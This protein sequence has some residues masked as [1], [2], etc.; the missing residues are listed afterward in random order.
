MNTTPRQASTEQI[1][2]PLFVKRINS[3]KRILLTSHIRPDGDC[4]GS[5]VAIC[6]AL[7]HLGKEVRIIN[8]H[9]VPPSLKFL[10]P[11]NKILQLPDLTDEQ[12]NWIETIDVFL[13]VDTS[14]WMQLGD[15]GQILKDSKAQKMVIDH[16]AI[17][18]DLGAEMF[19]DPTAE[20]AGVLCYQ[21]VE[22]LGVPFKTEIADPLFVAI[23]TDTG[24]FRYSSVRART[25]QVA[26]E[27]VEAG[28]KPDQLYRQIY[29]QESFARIRLVGQTLERAE[30]LENG[31]IMFTSIFLDDFDRFGALASDSEDI[32]NMLLQ[33]AGSEV[34]VILVDQRQKSENGERVS[35]GFKASFRSRCDLD[36]SMLAAKF[37]GG[38]HKRAAGATL[39]STFE[40]AKEKILTA[41]ISEY[42]NIVNVGVR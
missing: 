36:C 19:I 5:Q 6:K 34:A 9:A 27:L 40:E 4:I 3:A 7:E 22:A 16:H 42:K 23:A 33:V 39:F 26:A 28:V 31:K 25:Y 32:V 37:N 17:G 14:S 29:E 11:E 24:W 1:D 2:W 30:S 10:D 12:R 41:T 35:A 21:A 20:A 13:V 18:N 8:G 38:G 15:M